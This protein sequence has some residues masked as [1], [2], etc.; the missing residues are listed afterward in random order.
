MLNNIFLTGPV[1]VGKSTIL[2]NALKELDVSLG[3]YITQRVYQKDYMKF[4][5]K[6]LY[7]MEQYTIIEIDTN[8]NLKRVFTEVFEN[9]LI[10][11]LDKS[12]DHSDLIVLD[13]LGIAENDIEI[14]TTKVFQ[15]LDSKKIVFGVLKDSDCEFLNQIRNRDDVII[16]RITEE[17]RDHILEEILGILRDLFLS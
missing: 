11:I 1:G 9:G 12:I 14:F 8:R 16:I 5:V 3:G 7:D 17:N 4:I 6:S 15:L 2:Y 10:H 13:E